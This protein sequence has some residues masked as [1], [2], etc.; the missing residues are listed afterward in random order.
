MGGARL[1]MMGALSFPLYSLMGLLTH[2]AEG[3]GNV[4]HHVVP[5][6]Q[7]SSRLSPSFDLLGPQDQSF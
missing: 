3:L 5:L 1:T 7:T 4:S 6:L 2:P